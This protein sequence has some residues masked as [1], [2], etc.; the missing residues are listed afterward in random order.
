ML[1][2]LAESSPPLL[3]SSFSP[4]LLRADTGVLLLGVGVLFCLLPFALVGV[5]SAV[6]MLTDFIFYSKGEA[7]AIFPCRAGS[8]FAWWERSR[9][10]KNM[11]ICFFS[12]S[13]L[14]N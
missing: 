6:D 4:F 13:A 9:V 7:V 8:S 11:H 12:H 3:L 10:T 2:F 1:S 5:S 14:E